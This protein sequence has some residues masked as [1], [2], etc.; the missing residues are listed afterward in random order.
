[1]PLKLENIEIIHG[2]DHEETKFANQYTRQKIQNIIDIKCTKVVVG[3][4]QW[5]AGWPGKRPT[6]FPEYESH[7]NNSMQLMV[8][9]FHDAKID[10]YFR[11]TQ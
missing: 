5:D 10:L 8:E 1:M 4:G 3:T 11:T 6:P 7:L 2:E 9:M